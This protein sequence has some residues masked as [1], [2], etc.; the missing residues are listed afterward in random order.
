MEKNIINQEPEN[1]SNIEQCKVTDSQFFTTLMDSIT[2]V[3]KAHLLA[4]NYN[5]HTILQEYYQSALYSIDSIIEGYMSCNKIKLNL[6]DKSIEFNNLNVDSNYFTC[7]KTFIINND[8]YYKDQS[9]LVSLIDELVSTIDSVIYKLRMVENGEEVPV[10][11]EIVDNPF[12][13]ESKGSVKHFS[14][15]VNENK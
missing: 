6:Y 5:Q 12:A 15:W 10:G 8:C 9:Q 1:T 13:C 11:V 4:D 14:E 3:W 7:L 2:L